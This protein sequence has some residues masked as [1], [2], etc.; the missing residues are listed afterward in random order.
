LPNVLVVHF[1]AVAIDDRRF[2]APLK[3]EYLSNQGTTATGSL[4]QV[5]K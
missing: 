5:V 3:D 4:S 2:K 1:H